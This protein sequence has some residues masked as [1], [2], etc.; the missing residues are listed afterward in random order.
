MILKSLRLSVNR[1]N[2]KMA[3][4]CILCQVIKGK[5]PSYKVYEDDIVIGILD[6]NPIA[7][8]HCLII[9]KKHIVWFTDLNPA[10][11]SSFSR[12]VLVVS[13]RLKKVFRA[14]YVTVLIRGSRI[15]HLHAHLVPSIK[16]KSSAADRVLDIL[17]FVQENQ[18]PVVKLAEMKKIA[19]ALKLANP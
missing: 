13:K 1:E 7:Q 5:L 12:A 16:D 8:G 11:G 10:E 19:K 15:P 17:Q 14:R 18:K 3:K 9:P 2:H 6:I 4:D